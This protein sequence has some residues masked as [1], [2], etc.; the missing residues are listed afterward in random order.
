MTDFIS[1]TLIDTQIGTETNGVKWVIETYAVTYK[2][3][4][5]MLTDSVL[6]KV[7]AESA[8]GT[9]ILSDEHLFQYPTELGY[10]V[11][12][13]DEIDTRLDIMIATLAG[14]TNG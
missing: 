8:D 14:V 2:N 5:F 11:A 1:E 7:H 9:V 12:D 10:D 3:L 4:L 13:I 6:A